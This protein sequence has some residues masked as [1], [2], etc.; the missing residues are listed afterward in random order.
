M[1]R[2]EGN[3]ERDTASRQDDKAGVEKLY[4][5]GVGGEDGYKWIFYE[6]RPETTI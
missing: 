4:T 5:D 2:R 1:P 3:V 6:Y